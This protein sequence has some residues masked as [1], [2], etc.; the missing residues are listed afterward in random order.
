[1]CC[2][3]SIIDRAC[4]HARHNGK[5]DSDRWTAAGDILNVARKNHME[6][7][8]ATILPLLTNKPNGALL[9]ADLTEAVY[10]VLARTGMLKGP[11][12]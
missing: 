9:P 4:N 3:A 12:C 11:G 7:V 2:L 5:P 6:Y 8:V 1:M 10:P